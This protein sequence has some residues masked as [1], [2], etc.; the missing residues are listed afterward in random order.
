MPVV[1]GTQVA[2]YRIVER[3]GAG[4]MGVVYSAEDTRLGRTVALKFLPADALADPAAAE[5]FRREARA[6]SALNHPNICTVHDFGEHDGQPYLVMELLEGRTLRSAIAAGDLKADQQLALAVEIADALDVAHGRG[7]VHRDIKPENIFITSRGHAKVLDFGLAK[8]AAQPPAPD[9]ATTADA[10]TALGVTVG[11]LSYMSPEQARGERVDARSDLFSFGAVLYELVTGVQAFQGRTPAAIFEAVTRGTPAAVV[12]L[13]PSVPPEV[14][15]IIGR[16][17]EK[18]PSVRYQSA[19]DL[20]ADLRRAQ[21]D[22]GAMPVPGPAPRHAASKRWIG[23]GIALVALL[24][25]AFLLYSQQQAPALTEKDSVLI[26]DFEN[27][28]GEGV[29]DGALKQ[30]LAIHV[31]QSPFFNVVSG[32]RV[33]EQLRL[34]NR[35]PDERVTRA[36]GLEICERDG[37]TA[38]IVGAIAPLGSSYVLTLEAI[39]ARTGDTL[40]RAQAQAGTREAVLDALGTAASSLRKDLGESSASLERFDRPLHEATTSSL[41]ALRLYS[42]GRD[43][44]LQGHHAEALPSL[45]RA[46]DLDPQFVAALFSLAVA[47]SNQGIR[48][49]E[50]R[51]ALERAYE[52]RD[53]VTERERYLVSYLYLLDR[54]AFDQA[55]DLMELA[56][57]AYSR[58]YPFRNNLA[59]L[60]IVLGDY[61]RALEQADEGIRVAPTF[62]AVLYSNKG[63]A[64]R[65][66]GRYDEAKAVLAEV[67]AQGVDSVMTHLNLMSIAFAEGDEAAYRREL[68]WAKGRPAEPRLLE[69]HFEAEL[70]KGR[71]SAAVAADLV[72]L[73]PG[74]EPRIAAHYAAVGDCA[75]VKN[76]PAGPGHPRAAPWDPRDHAAAALGAVLCDDRAAAAGWL[77]G[78]TSVPEDNL[79][80]RRISVPVVQ[81]MLESR[82]GDH[83]AARETLRPARAWAHGQP[84]AFWILYVSGSI[85]LAD[86]RFDD[87]IADFQQITTRPSVHPVS[88]LIP[89]A[90]LG[91]ARAAA[92]A[93]DLRRARAAYDTLFGI[94]KDADPDLPAL[95]E[96][97]QEYARLDEGSGTR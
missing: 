29:F 43:L 66:L 97:R 23:G 87:A 79:P 12:R 2:Q 49:A 33:A 6:A 47:L 68:E 41:E 24:T 77:A 27:T 28:T 64:L 75:R 72:R 93:G 85:N 61:A 9:A 26:A 55:R 31:E 53:R 20:R 13:N 57:K 40:A 60:L 58:G 67:H 32:Q 83:V 63:W 18:D 45:R 94:W 50:Y 95:L 5:R 42:Q 56:A 59:S 52:L 80:L 21:R 16:A 78:T 39:E 15:R 19:A 25:I 96:A 86:G 35:A 54:Q 76:L 65:A 81:A 73:E 51:N 90:H 74:A 48:D 82:R 17:L 46:I 22:S 69:L 36:L 38:L 71:R 92:A 37:I 34:M 11:T 44:G 91:I 88:P 30:A 7:I 84:D 1:I 89:L 14:E 3:L 8:A 70:L 62:V 10:L 4:G